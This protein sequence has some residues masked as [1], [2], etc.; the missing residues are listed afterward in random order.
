M[1]VDKIG[2]NIAGYIN[3]SKGAQKV[4]RGIGKN[5]A[6]FSAATAFGL[7][8][9]VRPK[10]LEALPFKDDK[11]K[12]ASQATALASGLSDLIATT[13]IFIPLNKGIEKASQILLSSKGTFFEGNKEAISQYKSVTNRGAKL[14]LLVPL[15]IFRVSLVKPFIKKINEKEKKRKLDKC[16]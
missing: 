9:V 7:A 11:D 5:P 13:A 6:I 14:L 12:K 10:V 15:S 3:N 4:L 2:K 1:S 8:S 16:V